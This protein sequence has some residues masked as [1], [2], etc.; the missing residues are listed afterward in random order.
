[1]AAET[2]TSRVIKFDHLTPKVITRAYD[3]A[4]GKNLDH[5]NRKSLAAQRFVE[6]IT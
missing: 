5:Q 6:V 2:T 1:M 4:K 3:R